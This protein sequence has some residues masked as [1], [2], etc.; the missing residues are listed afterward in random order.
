MQLFGSGHYC[1][2]N[3]DFILS[4]SCFGSRTS[5]HV[6][7]RLFFRLFMSSTRPTKNKVTKKKCLFLILN[8]PYIAAHKKLFLTKSG[9]TFFSLV[10]V[11]LAVIFCTRP[12]T[13]RRSP[14]FVIYVLD[15]IFL[16]SF[17]SRISFISCWLHTLLND[18]I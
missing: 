17:F 6:S 13:I 16:T 14:L 4:V 10:D 5:M 8:E 9:S 3:K 15:V 12:T 7:A 11:G 2:C 18:F 1:C